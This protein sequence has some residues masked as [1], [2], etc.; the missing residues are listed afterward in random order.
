MKKF[1]KEHADLLLLLGSVY[2]IILVIQVLPPFEFKN[3][4]IFVILTVII[5]YFW[6]ALLSRDLKK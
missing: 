3:A 4:I 5:T 2:P 6:I 1:I